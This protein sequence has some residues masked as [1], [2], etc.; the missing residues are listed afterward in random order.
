MSGLNGE[1]AMAPIV[2]PKNLSD[3]GSQV[4]PPSVVLK[5]PEPVVPIQYSS[6]RAAEPATATERPPRKGP[7]SRHLRAVVSNGDTRD[8]TAE[9]AAGG[10]AGAGVGCCAMS[11]AGATTNARRRRD[12][13]DLSGWAWCELTGKWR[14]GGGHAQ[15]RGLR[16]RASFHMSV[17]CVF[18]ASPEVQLSRLP[19]EGRL[20]R[21]PEGRRVDRRKA[22]QVGLDATEILDGAHGLHEPACDHLADV[23][24]ILPVSAFD[25]GEGLGIQVE[26]IERD[27]TDV[28]HESTALLPPGRDGDE[29]R[30]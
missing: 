4:M 29:I 10:E 13:R 17:P 25:L 28:L 26:V 7:I 20:D 22:I 21:F 11:T 15:G 12:T 23:V 18:Q 8:G 19:P 27:A 3:M 6:G 16:V 9:A 30:R 1:T 2:P 5:T 14:E 24:E